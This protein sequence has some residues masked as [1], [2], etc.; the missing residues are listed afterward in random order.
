MMNRVESLYHPSGDNDLRFLPRTLCDDIFEKIFDIANRKHRLSVQITSSWEGNIRWAR[1]RTSLASNRRRIQVHV[2]MERGGVPAMVSTN[3]LDEASL[4]AA[5]HAVERVLDMQGENHIIQDILLKAP[6][7]TPPEVKIWSDATYNT[8]NETRGEIA[9]LLT[10]TAESRD[11]LAAG[12]IEMR[13][14]QIATKFRTLDGQV[15]DRY[16]RYTNAECS[17]TVRNALG[18]GSG[19]AGT[20]SYDWAAINGAAL[21][22]RALEKCEMSVNPVRIEPGRYTV[23]L[24]P[25]AVYQL[26]R[27]MLEP[28]TTNRSWIESRTGEGPYRLGYDNA[29]GVWRS[30]LGIKI[31]D[32]RITIRQNPLES[33]MGVIP[34]SHMIARRDTFEP[35]LPITWIER[36]VLTA[37]AY[38]RRY[39]LEKL[40][41]NLPLLWRPGFYMD[42]GESSIEEM[43]STTQRGLLVTRFSNISLLNLNSLLCTGVT[44]DGLWL[45]EDGTIKKA[46]HNFRFTES[47]L[48]ILNQVEL[49]GKP[50]PVYTGETSISGPA[51]AFVPPIRVKDFSFTS[52]VDAI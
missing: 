16:D 50:M 44:R 31:V 8:S 46:V 3:Q 2:A 38:D 47:P 33:Q 4:K 42:G 21:V 11:L 19:W 13:A 23:I 1:N 22:S 15:Q 27:V 49:L 20:S 26:V 10:E 9:R 43:I 40:N 41:D 6:E 34:M 48:F 45:I 7:F 28:V 39:A 35:I 18:T 52:L 24:E 5:V 36:G 37:L 17:M 32:E 51:P 12:F 30:K 29:L 14:G 25:Q